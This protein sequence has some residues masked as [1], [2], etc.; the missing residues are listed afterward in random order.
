MTTLPGTKYTVFSLNTILYTPKRKNPVVSVHGNNTLQG[1][2]LKDF[3]TESLILDTADPTGQF[4]WLDDKLS[5]ITLPKSVF[6]LGHI[7]PTGDERSMSIQ[8]LEPYQTRF[9]QILKKHQGET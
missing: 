8:W 4:Q 6:L 1:K 5:Q 7:P 3:N 9:V 2:G